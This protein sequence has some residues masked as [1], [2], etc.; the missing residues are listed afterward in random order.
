MANGIEPISSAEKANESKPQTSLP[1][2]KFLE[3]GE[4]MADYAAKHQIPLDKLAEANPTVNPYLSSANQF[5]THPQTTEQDSVGSIGSTPGASQNIASAAGNNTSVSST[6]NESSGAANASPTKNELGDASLIAKGA[7]TKAPSA[8][9]AQT[10]RSETVD[11]KG[12]PVKTGIRAQ[13]DFESRL[14]AQ[15]PKYSGDLKNLDTNIGNSK[16]KLPGGTYT[17][18]ENKQGWLTG[19]TTDGKPATNALEIATYSGNQDA[20][21]KRVGEF[22]KA[23]SDETTKIAKLEKEIKALN[24]E[25]TKP[26]T[27]WMK[28]LGN[29][30]TLSKERKQAEIKLKE[31]QS[32]LAGANKGRLEYERGQFINNA[33]LQ[34]S[35]VADGTMNQALANPA[36]AK[37]APVIFVNGVNTDTS[38]SGIEAMELSND[39]RVPV[40]HVVNVSSMNKLITGGAGIGAT[41][42]ATDAAKDA[43][44]TAAGPLGPIIRGNGSTIDYGKGVTGDGMNAVD[45]TKIDQ[46]IQ[47]HLTGNRK[48]SIT[49]ANAILDQMNNP[50]LKG[51]PIKVIGYSQ[52]A[53]IATQ[54]LR[55]VDS[56]LTE[57]V[58]ADK[59]STSP[60]KMTP[61]KKTELMSRVRLLGIGPGAADRHLR[62]ESKNGEV[63]AVPGLKDVKYRIIADKNDQIGK[64]LG[65][66]DAKANNGKAAG[67][68]A[69]LA[70]NNYDAHLS[71]FKTYPATD[72]GSRYNP[73]AGTEL[74]KWF[75]GMPDSQTGLVELDGKFPDKK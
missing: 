62:N 41:T 71:Y 11:A 46:R 27:D 34:S 65:V 9:T 13:L 31:G 50:A 49:T 21:V 29:T 28:Q 74:Q 44:S 48:A 56:N 66:G 39:L 35:K 38:R 32:L 58:N 7:P 15:D 51:Q 54:A 53:A 42:T 24:T 60:D 47:Q 59:N 22:N 20:A 75:S 45:A 5:V 17:P 6:S 18:L 12:N 2:G 73:Q 1:E 10:L 63:Q 30:V 16:T 37:K 8:D 40:N 4:T 64:L 70:K 26:E 69:Q 36:D 57:R 52:G 33:R 67:A 61:E 14:Q 25:L 68:A 43:A 23:I 19:K 3:P 55:E 72:P